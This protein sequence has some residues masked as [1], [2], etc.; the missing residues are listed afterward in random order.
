VSDLGPSDITNKSSQL[1]SCF[2]FQVFARHILSDLNIKPII[3]RQ[4]QLLDILLDKKTEMW[5]VVSGCL[6][7]PTYVQRKNT[8]SSKTI[9]LIRRV[10]Q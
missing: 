1:L 10:Q 5:N 7:L 6:N 8:N 2:S 4:T 9:N 3:K